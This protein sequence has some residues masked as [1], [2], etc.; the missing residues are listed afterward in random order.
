MQ[1]NLL[2]LQGEARLKE[3]NHSNLVVIAR[4]LAES[5]EQEQSVV[6]TRDRRAKR[7]QGT[8]RRFS[9]TLCS[10]ATLTLSTRS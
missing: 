9:T 6:L 2:T 1:R 7:R 8:R 10:S 4:N 5:P 3:T